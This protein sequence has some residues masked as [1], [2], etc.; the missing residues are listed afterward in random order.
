LRQ[1]FYK[2]LHP[3]YLTNTSGNC[4]GDVLRMARAASVFAPDA[5]VVPVDDKGHPV[6]KLE[7]LAP[8][9]GYNH[10]AAHD[11]LGDV[12]A[13][14]HISRLLMNKAPLIWSTAMRFS[15]KAA[16]IDYVGSER[17][18]CWCEFYF[19]NAYSWLVTP[20]G[21]NPDNSGEFYVYDL[22]V[23]PESLATLDDEQ[24]AARLNHSPKPVRRLKCNSSPMLTPVE[25]AP[26]M[27]AASALA[28]DELERRADFL[29]K[30]AAFRQRLIDALES[31]REHKE[32][33]LYIE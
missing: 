16:V 14:I 32:D 30:D 10:A 12:S 13:T 11:A 25:G 21:T 26:A 8:A 18:F 6:F 33:S 17:I 22:Q 28:M 9:N 15:Q 31:N 2:T 1:A 7:R 29:E 23:V 20:I 24:L 5:L 3:P 27:T 19:G 4:R